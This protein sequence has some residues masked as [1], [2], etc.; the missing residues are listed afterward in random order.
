MVMVRSEARLLEEMMAQAL[1]AL[2]KDQA[3]RLPMVVIYDEPWGYALEALKAQS[4]E[5]HVVLT[6][7]PCPEYLEDLWGL[8]P[9]LLIATHD[10]LKTFLEA[11]PLIQNG[12]RLKLIPNPTYQSPLTQ[13]ER[14]TLR[15]C[16]LGLS[17]KEIA[18]R[19]G[20]TAHAVSNSLNLI[21]QKLGL[22]GRTQAALYYWGMRDVLSRMNKA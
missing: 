3:F 16:A 19:R 13:A 1:N 11:I 14:L 21:Y 18:Q 22:K 2:F 10:T 9:A 20:V 6:G 12:Q 5:L 7:N 17:D 15:Y 8:H 4:D